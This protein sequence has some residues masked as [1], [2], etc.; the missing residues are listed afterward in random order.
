[1]FAFVKGHA[2]G[3]EVIIGF[4]G[5]DNFAFGGYGYSSTVTPTETVGSLGDVI[6][7]SDGTTITLAGVNHK[8]F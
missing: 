3:S 5:S 7:L 4:N 8:I 6:T 1:M 2:G